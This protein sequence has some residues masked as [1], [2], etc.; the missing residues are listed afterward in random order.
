MKIRLLTLFTLFASFLGAQQ[1]Y[2]SDPLKIDLLLSASFAELRS[3][4]FH[5]GIDIKTQGATG[6]PVYA[7]ADGYISRIAVSPTGFGKALYINHSNGTT[8]VYG[9]L[10][11]FA[12]EIQKYVV[13]Q[14]YKEES[15]R[16]DLQVPS[17]LFPVKRGDEIASSGNSGSSGGPHLHFEIRDTQSEEPLNPLELGFSVKDNLPPKF[18]SLLV[19]PLSDTSHVNYIAS[20]KSYPI[21]YYDGKY[22][23]KDNPVIPVYG[24]VGFAIQVNDYFDGTNN[25]CGINSLALTIAGEIQFA[26]KLNRFSFDD[27]RYINSHIVY[28]EWMDSKRRFVKTWI[29]PGNRLPIYTCNLS[30]GILDAGLKSYPVEIAV[31]DAYGNKSELVFKVEGKYKEVHR[32]INPG[33]KRMAFNH[34]NFF[35]SSDCVIEI[36]RGALYKDIDFTYTTRPTTTAYYSGFQL[37]GDKKAP[38]QLPA[39]LRIKPRSLRTDLQSKVVVVNVD[40]DNGA[41]AAVGGEYRNGWVETEVRTLGTYAVMVDTIAPSITPLSI[42]NNVLTESSRIR[43]TIRDNLSG[44]DRIVGL[45]DGKWALFDYDAKTN[46]ITHVF[47]KARFDFG[48]RHTIQLKV[49]DYRNNESI[50]EASFWK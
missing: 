27:T 17:S 15:F 43:F 39:K 44:V 46:R 45:L 16:V 18:F 10:E 3:N 30:Q 50:Y 11:R 49:S 19:V 37:I 34:D 32:I 38:L 9:H 5:S 33:S 7:V 26:F 42:E 12:P 40:A 21:V 8:S 6:L 13:D 2:Y 48:K 1:A 41:P 31:A 35:S 47:D 29:D 22:H 24:K 14:Q 23:L 4:H 25:K 28:E 20:A 36:P